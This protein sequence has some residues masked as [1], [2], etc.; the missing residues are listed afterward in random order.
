M[1]MDDVGVIGVIGVESLHCVEERCAMFCHFIC[2][3]AFR[4]LT[5][6]YRL[7]GL[8]HIA[9]M[10]LSQS[11]K[12]AIPMP[13]SVNYP[14]SNCLVSTGNEMDVDVKGLNQGVSRLGEPI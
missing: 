11:A 6:H 7:D 4:K 1:S 14:H 5:M 9:S 12:P 3:R 2:C 8:Y 13:V 10:R